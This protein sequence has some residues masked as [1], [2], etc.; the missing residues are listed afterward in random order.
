VNDPPSTDASAHASPV[1]S[2][3]SL[4][5]RFGY[6]EVL[7]ALDLEVAPGEHVTITGP[8][9]SGK[10]TLLRILAGLLKASSG[11]VSILGGTPSDAGVRR[12]I[13]VLS[14][15]PS[16]YPRMTASENMR[17]WGRLYDDEAAPARGRDILVRLGLDPDDRR[18]VGSY[19]Q[20]MRQRVAVAR[21]L[22]TDPELVLAD[23]P[24]AALDADGATVVATMLGAGRTLVAAT[25]DTHRFEGSR[26]LTLDRGRLCVSPGT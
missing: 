4:D 20:G 24:L 8:N 25:H 14:H 5:R 23:E 18:P 22:C 2:V 13:G 7:A 3:R 16:I 19:S 21:A 12:R 26:S 6:T 11:Q 9:G 1:V 17:F 15:S 10:T